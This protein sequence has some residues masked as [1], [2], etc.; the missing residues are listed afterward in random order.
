MKNIE[1]T[2]EPIR[3]L[4]KC[5]CGWAADLKLRPQSVLT[6]LRANRQFL[7]WLQDNNIPAPGQ[8]DVLAYKQHIEATRGHATVQLYIMALRRFYAW[9]AQKDTSYT[10]IAENINVE[11]VERAHKRDSLTADQAKI[12]LTAIDRS[13][14]RGRRDYA[15]LSLMVTCGLHQ[16]EAVNANIGDIG[17]GD[18]NGA[19]MYLYRYDRNENEHHIIKLPPAA[20]QAISDYL[21]GRTDGS[22]P[23]A[24]LFTSTCNKNRMQRL[25]TRSIC[26]IIKKRLQDAGYNSNTLTAQ[27]LRLTAVTLA[28]LDGQPL[29]EV[30]TFARHI[31]I[32][33]T[34]TY[35]NHSEMPPLGRQTERR[36]GWPFIKK[37][38][39]IPE[40]RCAE[41]VAKAIFEKLPQGRPPGMNPPANVIFNKS[42]DFFP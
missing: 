12:V 40:N 21:D 2:P 6:Y 7:R 16:S 15:M 24:P 41:A 34:L 20:A 11:Q 10:N 42:I 29:T 22:S 18:D 39:E 17:R 23:A 28:I 9:L 8:N 32:T 26:G 3:R 13:T 19:I 35:A 27:S 25:T 30:Q 38:P 4:E 5:L 37:R 14:E 1:E 33:T 36:A 31:N